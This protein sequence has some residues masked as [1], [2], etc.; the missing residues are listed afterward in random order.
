[1]LSKYLLFW[2]G[3]S[4]RRNAEKKM[5][6][7]TTTTS[8]ARTYKAIYSNNIHFWESLRITTVFFF[9]CENICTAW[10]LL[11]WVESVKSV[12]NVHKCF[13]VKGTPFKQ[14]HICEWNSIVIVIQHHHHRYS[15]DNTKYSI[16]EWILEISSLAEYCK[17]NR[18][19][20]GV[21]VH[22]ATTTKTSR[23]PIIDLMKECK[24]GKRHVSEHLK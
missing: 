19:I 15:R 21:L 13:D 10:S 16:A 4:K 7:T 2:V 20:H 6:T 23:Y 14:M 22:L 8:S 11:N 18:N 9:K 5:L 3:Q 1:M 17:T 24:S 12:K